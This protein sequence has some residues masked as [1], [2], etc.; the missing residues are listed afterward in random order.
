MKIA[1]GADHAGFTLKTELS[2]H[3]RGLGHEV[4]DAGTNS[5]ERTDYPIYGSRAA[6]LVVTGE[7]DFGLIVCGSGIGISIAANKVPGARCV[8]CTEPFSAQMA[9]RHNNANMLA[10]G[11]RFVGVDMAKAILDAFLEADFEGGRHEG[12]VELFSQIE[13]GKEL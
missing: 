6:R 8:V 12:R 11:E 9:R 2:E 13:Q 3:L 4:I 1:V 10:M 7:A 5:T